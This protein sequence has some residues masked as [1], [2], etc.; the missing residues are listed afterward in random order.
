MT[1]GRHIGGAQNGRSELTER[2]ELVLRYIVQHYILTT[3]P[4]GSRYLSKR[5]EEEA[6]S[7]ATIRNTMADLEEKGFISHPHTSAGRVPTDRGYRFY[8]D[9][10]AR[11]SRLSDVERLTIRD[12]IRTTVPT[13]MLMK[14]AS[15]I[16]GLISN[17]L[18]II[19]AP[20]LLN[21]TLE[22]IEL[23]PLGSTRLL[24]VLSLHAG[25]VRTVTL[26][27]HQEIVRDRLDAIV[28]VLNER[29]AGLTLR[30]IRTTFRDRI[31]DVS[32]AADD[33]I[34]QLLT[35]SVE[36]IFDE[37][38]GIERVQLSPTQ[39]LLR[40][41]EF[42]SPEQVRGIVEL[43][44]D[45]EMVIHLLDSHP[46]ASETVEVTIGA[47]HGNER[48][49][50]YS[51]LTTRYQVGDATGTIGLIG[52]K[53]MDYARLISVVA[54]IAETITNNFQDR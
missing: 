26:E 18:G 46:G 7:A 15:R 54:Y 1:P 8:V 23:V 34:V 38:P 52:P 41:P 45:E 44:E 22:Q 29:L 12:N 20:E 6:I 21:S 24:V 2:E 47:E 49:V 32:V 36:T 40:Q 3:T 27:V 9:T 37:A 10:I 35:D 5:L 42:A 50:N 30:V 28:S 48:L 14:E 13:P 11:M 25:M 51:L 31:R 43:I 19:A 4:V 17:Q 33:G 16:L 53:R 39:N